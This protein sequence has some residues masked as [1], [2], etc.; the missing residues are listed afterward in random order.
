[1]DSALV[2]QQVTNAVR[3]IDLECRSLVNGIECG[4][5]N[6]RKEFRALAHEQTGK[7]LTEETLIAW[8]VRQKL[9]RQLSNIEW[10]K[11]YP[12]NQRRKCD[13]VF[14]LGKS[15]FLWLE[16]KLAWKAWF[17]CIKGPIVSNPS[18]LSYLHGLNKTHSFR[19]DF[20]KL[21]G[22]HIP[23]TDS[24]AIC[25][26]GFESLKSPMESDVRKIVSQHPDWSLANETAWIDRRCN[27]FQ[28]HV[29]NWLM[30]QESAAVSSFDL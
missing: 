30:R 16:L 26:I 11:P 23:S 2:L 17:E 18:F 21:S 13:L 9:N 4:L 6:V 19:H 8:L 27:A 10:E 28:I 22:S 1:M 3:E 5:I 25:L 12:R 29:W 20:E 7:K 14:P 24:R 15:N